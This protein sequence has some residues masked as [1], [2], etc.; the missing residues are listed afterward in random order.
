MRS[1]RLRS[2]SRCRQMTMTMAPGIPVRTVDPKPS[3]R[4]SSQE[5]QRLVTTRSR[6]RRT[7]ELPIETNPGDST[8]TPKRMGWDLNPRDA[9]TSAGFQ[10]RRRGSEYSPRVH[11]GKQGRNAPEASGTGRCTRAP[12]GE[13]EQIRDTTSQI[14][15]THQTSQRQVA[16][17]LSQNGRGTGLPRPALLHQERLGDRHRRQVE[18]WGMGSLDD[19]LR[20]GECMSDQEKDIHV[21]TVVGADGSVRVDRL[22]YQAGQAVGI[23]IHPLEPAPG[24]AS[25]SRYPLAGLPIEY[26]EPFE[27]MASEDWEVSR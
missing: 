12:R 9:F 3:K 14:E 5:P 10:G 11:H 17:C 2:R 27:G 25:P 7:L 19:G 4:R 13:T 21:T 1:G 15:T 20:R 22:P 18:S 6:R 24:P 23:T 16:T 26:R 8:R